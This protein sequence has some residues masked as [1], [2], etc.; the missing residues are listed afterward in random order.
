MHI[1]S[2]LAIN[3]D[4]PSCP[5]GTVFSLATTRGGVAST[6]TVWHKRP[7]GS[8]R[9]APLILADARGCQ[10]PGCSFECNGC[11]EWFEFPSCAK[12][13]STAACGIS[14]WACGCCA[15]KAAPPPPGTMA[16]LCSPGGH[17]PEPHI[18]ASRGRR[19]VSMTRDSARARALAQG[20]RRTH[21][22]L[23]P[24]CPLV[25]ISPKK[26]YI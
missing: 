8:Q 13:V 25:C 5:V 26:P 19:P 21:L 6:A 7:E 17:I 2:F 4:P 10:A 22:C 12:G 9:A 16:W 24:P 18:H 3:V 15:R 11:S 1:K 14:G 20:S 23:S